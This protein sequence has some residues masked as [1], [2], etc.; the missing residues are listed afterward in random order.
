MSC[1]IT[2]NSI[3]YRTLSG[4]SDAFPVQVLVRLVR[5]FL[6][7]MSPKERYSM[8]V[9]KTLPVRFQFS[10]MVTIALSLSGCGGSAPE[11]VKSAP[12]APSNNPNPASKAVADPDDVPI[13]AADVVKP[14]NYAD[15][16]T[17]IEGYRNTIRDE[18]GAGRPTKAHRGLDELD[19]VLNQLPAIARDSGVP[20]DQ[21]EKINT[22][23]KAIQEL[24]N[25]VHSRIDDKKEP[26]YTSVSAA[27]D[28]AI[29]DLKAI[30]VAPVKADSEKKS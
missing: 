23:A 12:T 8:F 30:S 9:I 18:I 25:Q 3:R 24:F 21:W 28:K 1:V 16:L 4:L 10:L 14:K 20:K 2:R 13:K 11:A 27:I 26:N 17:R 5:L 15:A 7:P 22:T 19:I 6:F 29:N